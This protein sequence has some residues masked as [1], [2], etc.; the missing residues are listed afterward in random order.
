M[1]APSYP[2]PIHKTIIEP[3][4]GSA[5]YS[6]LYPHKQVVLYDKNPIIVMLWEYLINVSEK[7]ILSLPLLKDDQSIEDLDV[8]EEA[9]NLIGFWL[10][11]G[12]VKPRK[13]FTKSLKKEGW[14]KYRKKYWGPAKKQRIAEQLKFI[15]HWKVFESGYVEVRNQEAT[16]F[17][18]PPYKKAGKTYPFSSKKI[19]FDHLANWCKSRQGTVIVCESSEANWLDFIKVGLCNGIKG[20]VSTEAVW[21]KNNPQLSLFG[22]L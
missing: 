1:L 2:Q 15:R 7:E 21:I 20:S 10:G 12:S 18:D 11:F 9:K 16:W 17:I 8:I 22:G 6:L 4:C 5:C 3:F 19:D 13:R 14:E